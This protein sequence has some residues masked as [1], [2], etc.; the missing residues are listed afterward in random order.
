MIGLL[1]GGCNAYLYDVTPAQ[2]G[3]RIPGCIANYHAQWDVIDTQMKARR[4]NKMARLKIPIYHFS[5]ANNGLA[6]NSYGGDLS[7][8]DAENFTNYFTMIRDL[9]FVQV[10][11]QFCPEWYND[12]AN[13]EGFSTWKWDS[14]NFT[15]DQTAVPADGD[16]KVGNFN[17]ENWIFIGN[18]RK[19]LR[20]IGVNALFDPMNEAVTDKYKEYLK[21]MWIN[22]TSV[23]D[24][25][26][27]VM[28]VIPGTHNISLLPY[29]HSGNPPYILD[30]H[31][32]DNPDRN[33]YGY[34]AGAYNAFIGCHRDTMNIGMGATPWIL[35]EINYQ[36]PLQ[37]SALKLASAAANQPI[38]WVNEW[39]LT[40]AA[41]LAQGNDDTVCT[42]W[43]VYR[44]A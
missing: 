17:A 6:L 7:G 4:A 38:L 40:R 24:K 26:D 15:K 37:A 2:P 39:G 31:L 42:D 10:E 13:W 29:I 3:Q 18:I 23:F 14:V 35:G 28:S 1:P 30:F 8:Q 22:Y 5:G 9:G 12:P 11:I 20:A 44:D 19:R 16:T 41:V 36:D 25:D 21:L 43:S 27:A 33:D 34:G 32:Y